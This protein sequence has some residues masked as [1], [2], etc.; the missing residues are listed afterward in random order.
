MDFET[1]EFMICGTSLQVQMWDTAGQERFRCIARSY[2]RGADV[3]MVAFDVTDRATLGS[4]KTWVWEVQH[5]GASPLN[6]LMVGTKLD[7]ARQGEK[8]EV[9]AAAQEVAAELGAELWMVSSRTGDNVGQMFR[10]MAALTFNS[11]VTR[12]E[13]GVL[14]KKVDIGQVLPPLKQEDIFEKKAKTQCV[15][16]SCMF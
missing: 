16:S 15:S 3:I 7:L 6:I 4:V 11:L 14:G 2:Y 1:V 10:R 8:E 9:E 12:E 5:S 13:R